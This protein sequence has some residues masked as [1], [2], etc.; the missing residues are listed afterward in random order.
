[1]FE[2]LIGTGPQQGVQ[3]QHDLYKEPG[4]IVI[5]VFVANREK[6]REQIIDLMRQKIEQLGPQTVSRHC[7]DPSK[8]TV[9]DIGPKS[10]QPQD[11]LEA[12]I[13]AS[14]QAVKDG[15]LVRFLSPH[16]ADPALHYERAVAPVN[17]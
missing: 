15:H 1:M 7:C 5:N 4:D 8:A 9:W 6:P 10:V 3:K 2:N 12:L 16:N 14:E 13:A 17:S 11:R